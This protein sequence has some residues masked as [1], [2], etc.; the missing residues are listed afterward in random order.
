MKNMLNPFEIMEILIEYVNDAYSIS[1]IKLEGIIQFHLTYQDVVYDFFV[2]V[3]K[4]KLTLYE[5]KEANST[6]VLKSKL[7]HFLDLASGKLNPVIGVLTRRLRFSGDISFFKKVMQQKSIFT[8]GINVEKYNDTMN[9]FE[10]NPYKPWIEPKSVL[11]INASPRAKN[12]YTDFYLKPFIEGLEKTGTDVEVVYLEK[13]KVNNCKGCLICMMSESGD[14]IHDGK[15]EFEL[16]YEKQ[17]NAD[18]IVFAFPLYM[19]GMPAVLKNYFDRTVRSDYSFFT[20]GQSK[21]R[22]SRRNIKNQT[23]M[24]FSICG[25]PE[26]ANFKAVS[27]HFKQLSTTKHMPLVAEVYRSAAIYIYNNPLMYQKLN[28]IMDALR[29]AGEEIIYG[30]K[31][32]IM[33]KKKIEQDVDKR[34]NFIKIANNF[35]FKKMINNEKKF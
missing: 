1:E 24:V 11:V 2:D 27:E 9:T 21:I 29:C 18:L 35:F 19:D 15:D 31:I 33:T 7:Y 12:G 4:D 13:L 20:E 6:V 22:H 8:A 16:L 26:K 32:R 3:S 14:C 17:L 30:G 23:M 25:Y 28:K 10:K 5:G 34:S